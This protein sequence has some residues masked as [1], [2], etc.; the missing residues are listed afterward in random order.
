MVRNY[1]TG[2]RRSRRR[3]DPAQRFDP[4]QSIYPLVETVNTPGS[5]SLDLGLAA[6]DPTDGVNGPVDLFAETGEPYNIF[7]TDGTTVYPP[8]AIV[9]DSN[10]ST[11]QVSW[12]GGLPEGTIYLLVGG[13]NGAVR[14]SK[15]EWLG[16]WAGQSTI[17]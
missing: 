10:T 11:L 9:F 8:D 3:P 6:I 2:A 12:S 1:K 16:A 4:S 15:G 5:G 7:A 13:L 14:G 17:S